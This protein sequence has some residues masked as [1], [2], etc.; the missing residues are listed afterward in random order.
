[1]LDASLPMWRVSLLV[2][3]E[4]L[5][6]FS[7]LLYGELVCNFWFSTQSLRVFHLK[8]VLGS[9]FCSKLSRKRPF[10]SSRRVTLNMCT[11][12]AKRYLRIS[13]PV[14]SIVRVTLKSPAYSFLLVTFLLLFIMLQFRL[15]FAI[16]SSSTKNSKWNVNGR[17]RDNLYL[18]IAGA[19][20]NTACEKDFAEMDYIKQGY[21]NAHS[22]V[23][24]EPFKA[25][26]WLSKG[27]T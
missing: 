1:L 7:L 16:L 10:W 22:E 18:L 5:V 6:I 21:Q 8:D 14:S 12:F 20:Q 25:E 26:C 24:I 2:F 15:T 4:R 17:S 27:P 9:C 13:S 19:V 3:S 11:D 23:C